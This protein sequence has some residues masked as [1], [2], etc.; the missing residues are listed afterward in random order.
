M[1][2]AAQR[3]T[4]LVDLAQASFENTFV[5]DLPA[6]PVLINVPRQVSN[7]CYTRVEPTPVAA[8]K[9]W[10]RWAE[11]VSCRQ[12]NP[13][14]HAMA[15]TSSDIGRDSLATAARSRSRNSSL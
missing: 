1:R 14:P 12:C 13:T 5:R 2:T 10:K 9:P 11:T 6:D 3:R 7:A 4:A 8:P 15:A